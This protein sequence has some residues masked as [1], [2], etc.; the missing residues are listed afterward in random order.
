MARPTNPLNKLTEKEREEVRRHFFLQLYRHAQE[1]PPVVSSEGNA[2]IT[3]SERV[4]RVWRA[5]SPE[6]EVLFFLPVEFMRG[7]EDLYHRALKIGMGS[8]MGQAA[9]AQAEVGKASGKPLGLASSGGMTKAGRAKKTT[10]GDTGGRRGHQKDSGT[11]KQYK[12]YATILNED[13]FRR[14]AYIDD[15]LVELIALIDAPEFKKTRHGCGNW[16]DAGQNYCSKCGM[17]L[18]N[19]PGAAAWQGGKGE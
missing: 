5:I 16:V 19:V 12:T 11:G 13:A 9:D 18:R 10:K 15:K 4:S 14:K 3:P 6:A 17:T 2:L 1:R 7:Y 8:A